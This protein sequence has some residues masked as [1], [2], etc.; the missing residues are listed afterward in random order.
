VLAAVRQYGR[1]L[2]YAAD[3]LKR[4]REVFEAAMHQDPFVIGDL[5]LVDAING[6]FGDVPHAVHQGSTGSQWGAA[7]SAQETTNSTLTVPNTF[8]A[9]AYLGEEVQQPETPRSPRLPAGSDEIDDE[10][11]A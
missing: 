11:D 3:E 5:G 10:T 9:L 6:S 8:D 4:D 7:S 2:K 1:A